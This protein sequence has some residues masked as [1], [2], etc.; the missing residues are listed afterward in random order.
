[1]SKVV[2]SNRIYLDPSFE[3]RQQLVEKLTHKIKKPPRPGMT[4]FNMYDIIKGYKLLPRGMISIPSGR[5]D[6]IPESSEII[7]RRI[8][9]PVELPEPKIPLRGGQ[10]KV[11]EEANDS[12]IINAKVGWGKSISALHLVKKLGQKTLI[13]C[14]NT[15]LRDQWIESIEALYPSIFIGKIGSGEFDIDAPIVVG[16]IQTLTKTIPKIAKEFG[17]VILDECLDYETLVDTEDR[18]K[19]KI[20][21][22]VNQKIDTKVLSLNPI[23]GVSS[24]KKVLRYFKNPQTDCLKVSHSGG[25]GFKC[26]PN[27]GV[28][29][30]VDREICR[31]PAEYLEIGDLVIQ[32]VRDHKSTAVLNNEWYP[33][34]LGMLLG[35]GSIGYPHNKSDSIRLKVTHGEAQFGYLAWKA[36]ILGNTALQ[37]GCSGYSSDRRIRSILTKSFYDIEDWYANIYVNGSK[38]RVPKNIANILTKESWALIFQDDGSASKVSDSIVFSVCE[39][40]QESVSNLQTSLHKLFNIDASVQFVCNKGYRYLRLN[41][42]DALLFLNGINGLVHPELQ[43]KLTSISDNIKQFNFSIPKTPLL[44]EHYGVR[45]VVSVTSSTLTNGYRYNIEVEDNHTYFANGI[46]VSN[47]H[48]CPATTFS[49]FLDGM[50]ARYKIGL[51]GTMLRKDGKHVLFKDFFGPVV[52]QPPQEN[53]MIPTV[54]IV[55]T[56]IVLGEGDA[57]TT[58]V[59]TLLYDP[60]Y[61]EFIAGVAKLQQAKGHKVLVIADRVEFLQNVGD[62]IGETCVCIVGGTDFDQRKEFVRQIESGEKTAIAGSRKIFAEGISVNPLS[63]VILAEPMASEITLEQIIGRIMRESEGKLQPLVIDMNFNGPSDRAQNKARL[64]FYLRQGWVV[65]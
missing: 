8:L 10:I 13:V 1:M 4:R 26:T 52:F 28:Y 23:T 42:K 20:G 25:G 45:K 39:F 40:D 33:I 57:W 37:E 36:N 24:Y 65:T 64:G 22:L 16:N 17:T 56:G 58:K 2:I 5:V 11:I 21:V 34:I 35:D 38:K 60:K 59:N 41:K 7:D 43:Y 51:S 31:V 32:T 48:H 12:C 63:C 9:I 55:K 46:L 47:C 61:Q 30:L 14:H 6:L 19:L 53:T 27:H 18:G 44:N 62:L 15:M 54:K 49:T 3:L 29:I 50:Y